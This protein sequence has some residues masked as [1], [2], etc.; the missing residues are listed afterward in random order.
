[1]NKKTFYPLRE[2]ISVEYAQEEIDQEGI[3]A[4]N[5]LLLRVLSADRHFSPDPDVRAK[6]KYVTLPD[7][8]SNLWVV[9]KGEYAGTFPKRVA[10]WLLKVHNERAAKIEITGDNGKPINLVSAIGNIARLHATKKQKYDLDFTD[11]FDW[12]DGDY[13]DNGS[14]YWG[15][16]SGAKI[17]LADHDSIAVRLYKTDDDQDC[18][19]P[20]RGYQYRDRKG[21]ARAWIV[22]PHSATVYTGGGYG[23]RTDRKNFAIM[24]NTY[25]IESVRL[26]RVLATHF[27]WSYTSI[28]LTC[29]GS[30]SGMLWIN[31][32]DPDD[33]GAQTHKGYHGTGYIL[34][35]PD[36]IEGIT[37]VDLHWEEES[38]YTC[39]DCGCGLSEDETR[40]FNGE[41]T[42]CES[43]YDNTYFY[44]DHCNRDR[45]SEDAMTVEGNMVCDLCT[46]SDASKCY[47]CED[48][49]W[50][51]NITTVGHHSICHHCISDYPI[52][53]LCN[54]YVE[55]D[56]I[57]ETA[58]RKAIC[59]DCLEDHYA[60]CDA[61]EKYYPT[62]DINDQ[63]L[64]VEC[65]PE[66][67]PEI[68]IKYMG[69]GG[70][71]T[72]ELLIASGQM[73]LPMFES[74]LH[75]AMQIA[76]EYSRMYGTPHVQ[77]E[78]SDPVVTPTDD[79]DNPDQMSLEDFISTHQTILTPRDQWI[80]PD[81]RISLAALGI[82]TDPPPGY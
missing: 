66:P 32:N 16:H 78:P 27:G 82:T 62:D 20:I 52:C 5:D 14:C 51:D 29:N 80:V 7:D 61:C 24:Y 46:D 81:Q 40:S 12:N 74:F 8:F 22:F 54:E 50:Y 37:R 9:T 77:S 60:E 4:V 55:Q 64:C 31:H 69:Y 39:D 3:L 75:A 33:R 15:E 45:P 44:C 56:D 36:E 63:G 57:T 10:S 76:K 68:E 28:E 41:G 25:G 58:D 34:G 65:T 70:F 2:I 73:I 26:A 17:M 23:K 59:D 79:P 43:C 21:Y 35:A 11:R 71:E 6:E 49:Y 67:D 19:M 30:T 38:E 18:S 48:Y 53:E 42:Y 72:V 1:M 47:D 13:G